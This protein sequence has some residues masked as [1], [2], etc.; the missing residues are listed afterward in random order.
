MENAK[1]PRHVALTILLGTAVAGT[2]DMT[3]ACFYWGVTKGVAPERI[4]QSVA[5]GLLGK[6]AFTGGAPAA[7]LG[8]AAHF[9]IMAV[10]V[11]CYVLAGLRLPILTRRPV[12]M[13]LAYGLAT[14]AVMNF[15]VLPLSQARHGGPFVLSTFVNNLGAHLF[16]VGVPIA[17]IAASR[18]KLARTV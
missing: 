2:L 6:A 4:F 8:M 18:E 17:L 15:L 9:G 3:E 16:M 13:G 1:S 14:Y 10:M 11:A 7:V 12:V 5:S